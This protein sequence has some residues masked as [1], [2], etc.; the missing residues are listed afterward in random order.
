MT[1]RSLLLSTLATFVLLTSSGCGDRG[2]DTRF[3][4]TYKHSLATGSVTLELRADMTFTLTQGT[5]AKKST[6]IYKIEGETVTL[7]V[8]EIDGQ[9]AKQA[10]REYPIALTRIGGGVLKGPGQL[11]LKKQ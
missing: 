7:I 8:E 9:T 1:L 3:V 5:A 10:D 2:S 11:A 6:G 4:G